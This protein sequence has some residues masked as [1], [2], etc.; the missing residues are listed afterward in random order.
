MK[1]TFILTAFA[2]VAAAQSI[3]DLPPCSLS[4]LTTAIKGLG[5]GLTDF[6]CSCK[7]ASELTP[8]ITPC[9]QTACS[10]PADQSKTLGAL[11]GICAAAGSPI[12]NAAPASSALAEE[13]SPT[14]PSEA[15]IETQ[16]TATEEPEYPVY[17]TA[18]TETTDATSEY[19]GM[20][21]PRRTHH[22]FIAL[23]HTLQLLPTQLTTSPTCHL[24]TLTSSLFLLSSTPSLYRVLRLTLLLCLAFF[25]PTP[26]VLLHHLCQGPR[27]VSCLLTPRAWRRRNSRVQLR[28]CRCL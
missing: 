10:D 21:L 3:T 23:T 19:P 15:P 13:T 22:F 26:L 20:S 24:P 14:L 8:V 17:P 5:C 6:A 4:C 7:K 9:V 27:G 16:P 1:N 28:Q 12:E 11:A 18:T 2:A 25:P